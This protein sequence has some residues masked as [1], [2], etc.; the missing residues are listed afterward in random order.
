M[1]CEQR[2]ARVHQ[3]GRHARRPPDGADFVPTELKIALVNRCGD[4]PREDRGDVVRLAEG[5]PRAARRRGGDARA[6][7]ASP[8]W[9]TPRWCPTC[10]APSARSTRS[11]RDQPRDVDRREPQPGQPAHDVRR[12]RS[13]KLRRVM[14]LA[15]GDD[16]AVNGIVVHASAARSRASA[17]GSRAWVRA[18]VD[19]GAHGITLGDT[20]GMAYPRQVQRRERAPAAALPGR[21]I[22]AA[23]PQHARHG[24]GERR[25]P[26]IEAGVTSFDASLGGIGGCPYAPGAPAT[27]APR[28]SCTRWS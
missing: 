20:T 5:D 6:S 10:A 25:W 16:C 27:S 26:G 28:T 1:L 19:M 22:H 9:S 2:V 24:P 18:F 11:R 3:R 12:S 4:R 13:R 8:A 23:L 14:A 17:A 15:R 7:S 21:G